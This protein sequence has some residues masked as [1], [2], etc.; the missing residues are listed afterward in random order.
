VRFD[1]QDFFEPFSNCTPDSDSA[2]GSSGSNGRFSRPF[3]HGAQAAFVQKLSLPGI[4]A[5]H[6]SFMGSSPHTIPTVHQA[7]NTTMDLGD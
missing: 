4:R 6:L 7:P 5:V 3:H 2:V 1:G